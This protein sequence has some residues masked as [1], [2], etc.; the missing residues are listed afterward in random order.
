MFANSAFA[1]KKPL[2][3][4]VDSNVSGQGYGAAGCGLGSIVFGQKKG[5]VQIFAA[6]T[7]GTSGSQTFGISSGTS[8]CAEG[9]SQ[10]SVEKFVDSNRVALANDMSRG[11]GETLAGLSKVMGC[12]DEQALGT[13]LQKN[14]SKVFPMAST[15]ASS[16]AV[17]IK[18]LVKSD[19]SLSK[20]C[21]I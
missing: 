12:S 1:A 8:N 18:N 16:A 2:A 9:G 19:S 20:T 21:A 10:A 14:Y 11:S 3:D 15:D 4:E 6:T 7:N 5:F 13:T 17:S